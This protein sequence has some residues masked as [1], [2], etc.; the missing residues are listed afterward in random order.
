MRSWPR[1]SVSKA[2]VMTHTSPGGIRAVL[3]TSMTPL[4]KRAASAGPGPCT[5]SRGRRRWRTTCRG[6][7]VSL[8]AAVTR[9]PLS[10]AST[11]GRST[12]GSRVE[13]CSRSRPWA[14]ASH[15]TSRRSTSA[16]GCRSRRHLSTSAS[17]SK[18]TCRRFTIRGRQPELDKEPVAQRAERLG[19]RG[20]ERGDQRHQPSTQFEPRDLETV[21]ALIA[22][23]K[24]RELQGYAT[25]P[26]RVLAVCE[27]VEVRRG[28]EPGSREKMLLDIEQADQIEK[29]STLRNLIDRVVGEGDDAPLTVGVGRPLHLQ[30][31]HS[32]P[33]DIGNHDVAMVHVRL[34]T[35]RD[36]ATAGTRQ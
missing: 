32:E 33:S 9:R 3:F 11:S 19:R 7:T 30:P 31:K 25:R 13:F 4:T 29:T 5:T 10:T 34:H 27:V 35:G 24:T 6:E 22:R 36:Q 15:P 26:L 16:S 1:H 23:G 21:P 12:S 14:P 20:A 2:R 28:H 17:R 8:G 18:P